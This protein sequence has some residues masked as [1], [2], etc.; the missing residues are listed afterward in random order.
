MGLTEQEFQQLQDNLQRGIT[1]Q[2]EV[3]KPTGC[4]IVNIAKPR[5][6]NKWETQY[7]EFLTLQRAAGVIQ[8]FA[9]EW[10]KLRLASGAYFKPDFAVVKE[11][12]LSFHE[13]KGFF[14]EAARVR[15]K[16]AAEHFPF[17]FYAVTK[18]GGVWQYEEIGE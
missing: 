1:A 18:K 3:N 9:F 15:I 8:W 10:I 17:P 12:Q 11:G 7:A 4:R 13:V 2:H 16:V 6:M 5:G 14:R